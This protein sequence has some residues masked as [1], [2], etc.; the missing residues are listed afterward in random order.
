MNSDQEV[1]TLAEVRVE[2][3]KDQKNLI[4]IANIV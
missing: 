4:A 3:T 2:L 1:I